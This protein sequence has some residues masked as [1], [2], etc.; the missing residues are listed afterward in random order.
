M[1]IKVVTITH[2][3]LSRAADILAGY[4]QFEAQ[5]GNTLMSLTDDSVADALV[6][7]GG[8]PLLQPVKIA[9]LEQV[10]K[11]VRDL[12]TA[13]ADLKQFTDLKVAG[14]FVEVTFFKREV[15]IQRLFNF[16]TDR[17]PNTGVETIDIFEVVSKHVN[18]RVTKL[19]GQLRAL[20]VDPTEA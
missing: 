7:A 5:I 6:I 10:T 11:L 15:P 13:R 12:N 8:E 2:E 18:E 17:T 14:P 1:T 19:E 20:G 16:D 4:G 9:D 3:Q